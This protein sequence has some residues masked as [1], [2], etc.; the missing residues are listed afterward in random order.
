MGP[1][2]KRKT[3]F[4]AQPQWQVGKW[5]CHAACGMPLTNI[6]EQD[7]SNVNSLETQASLL[8][9]LYLWLFCLAHVMLQSK[10]FNWVPLVLIV[11]LHA[12]LGGYS[13]GL[14]QFWWV[15]NTVANKVNSLV[16]SRLQLNARLISLL[17]LNNPKG[18]FFFYSPIDNF[19]GLMTI[20]NVSLP[21][22]YFLN[23]TF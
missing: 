9:I 16:N 21:M 6:A 20:F 2:Q 23:W 19:M 1:S 4:P 17:Q 3:R 7:W 12:V 13:K 5:H 22:T 14:W 8:F 18:L 10:F 15:N 11:T